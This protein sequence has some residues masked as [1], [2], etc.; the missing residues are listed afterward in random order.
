M[1]QLFNSYVVVNI[2]RRIQWLQAPRKCELMS[3]H[4]TS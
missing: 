1:Y 4:G 2:H 3:E